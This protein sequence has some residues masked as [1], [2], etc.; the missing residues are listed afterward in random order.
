MGFHCIVYFSFTGVSPL[1]LYAKGVAQNPNDAAAKE[2][3]LK[4]AKQVS[5][6]IYLRFKIFKDFQ[7]TVYMLKMWFSEM[8]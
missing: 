4:S 5:L 1:I 8:Q 6:K 7:Y 2:G 3:Y